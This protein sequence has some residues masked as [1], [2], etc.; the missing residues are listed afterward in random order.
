MPLSMW[1]NSALDA[2]SIAFSML[3]SYCGDKTD[4]FNHSPWSTT[5]L[6]GK[7]RKKAFELRSRYCG[8]N[9]QIYYNLNETKGM[10]TH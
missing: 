6:S 5:E 10:N 2:T 9:H 1:V 7:V 4:R 3:T 8:I